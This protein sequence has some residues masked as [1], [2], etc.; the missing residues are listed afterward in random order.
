MNIDDEIEYLRVRIEDLI[1]DRHNAN[2]DEEWDR[3]DFIS[4]QIASLESDLD[5]LYEQRDQLP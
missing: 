1:S 3:V 5:A 4:D 2:R